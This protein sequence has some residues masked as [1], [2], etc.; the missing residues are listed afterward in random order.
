[1]AAHNGSM[2]D[3]DHELVFRAQNGDSDAYDQLVLRHQDSI[4]RQ[5]YRYS[6]NPDVQEDLTQTVFVNAYKALPRYKP[7]APFLNWL[8]A[9][10][11]RVGYEYWRCEEKRLKCVPYHG[12]EDLLPGPEPDISEE[13]ES[14][15]RQLMAVMD[16]LRPSERQILYLLYVDGMS[17]R[18]AA[19][20]MGWTVSMAKMRAFR[21]RLKLRRIVKIADT[22]K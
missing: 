15:F 8:R 9:I 17:M 4:A 19:D 21:A 11:T 22:M 3:T 2:M 1:M 14:R 7:S 13:P 10:A 18:D 20:I 16:R 5:M 12:K 6:S